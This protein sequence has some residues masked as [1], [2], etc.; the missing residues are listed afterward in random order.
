MLPR[1]NSYRIRIVFDDDRLEV[2]AVLLP[3]ATIAKHLGLPQLVQQYLSCM[4][5]R[6][7]PTP[8]TS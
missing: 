8:E 2:D 3:P 1:N 7:G 6:G 4:R 5:H